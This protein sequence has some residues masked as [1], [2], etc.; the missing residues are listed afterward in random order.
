[1]RNEDRADLSRMTGW[2]RYTDTTRTSGAPLVLLANTDTNLQLKKDTVIESQ[3]PDDVVTF[4]DGAP[5]YKITGRN[6]DNLDL[7]LYF[8]AVP[9][10]VSQWLDVWINIGGSIFM[11]SDAPLNVYDIALNLDRSHKARRI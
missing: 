11:R 2:V 6:G 5:N 9:S 1:M 10:A 8:K 3:K 4:Y 7:M